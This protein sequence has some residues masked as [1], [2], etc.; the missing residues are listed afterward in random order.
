MSTID[1]LV[2][3]VQLYPRLLVITG[4]GCSQPS[5]IPTYRDNKGEWQRSTPIQH[6]DFIN[7]DATRKRYWARSYSGWP[8]I[9][10]AK[11]NDAHIHLRSLEELG[12]ILTLVTQNVDGLHQ[13]AGHN[14]VV[15][16]HGNLSEVICTQ[17][18]EL[19]SRDRLQERISEL[20][21]TLST[22]YDSLQPD[23]DA[24]L[25]HNVESEITK[26]LVIPQCE[27]CAGVLKPNVVFFGGTVPKKTVESIYETMNNID[28]L[29]IV[30]SSLMV[31]SGYRFCKRA[32]AMGIPIA[33]IN[34]G[35]TRAD[36]LFKLKVDQECTSAMA[37]LVAS[38]N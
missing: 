11:P 29:L 27:S 16:L 33:A 24:S 9:K 8:A 4:A 5:G 10:N 23:G 2:R 37:E 7:K 17:C 35:T 38:I 20:N 28:G 13:A 26:K 19:S 12:Y 15:D 31:Y 32:A 25:D 22:S 1:E 3:F 14:K 30:G 21:P 36:E 18:A 6:N 34:L